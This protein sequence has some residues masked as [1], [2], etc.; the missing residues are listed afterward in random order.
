MT[1]RLNVDRMRRY[2]MRGVVRPTTPVGYAGKLSDEDRAT[3][4][5]DGWTPT[6][7]PHH[8][9]TPNQEEA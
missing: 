1:R 3:L 7:P 5:T 4:R 8:R 9:F 2:R 6:D